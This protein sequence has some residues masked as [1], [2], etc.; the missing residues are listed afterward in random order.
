MLSARGVAVIAALVL[1]AGCDGSSPSP[2]PTTTI[3]AAKPIP[4]AGDCMAKE[5][6]D[7]DD[8]APDLNSRVD[9]TKPH[10][11]EVTAVLDVPERF[12]TGTTPQ[13]IMAQR[14]TL[15]TVSNESKANKKF[16]DYA[17]KRCR[18]AGVA[19]A[20]LSGLKLRGTSAV[21]ANVYAAVV[22]VNE[23]LNLLDAGNWAK[24]NTKFLCTIRYSKHQTVLPD[25][26]E[27]PEP[28]AIRSP[29]KNPVM[30]SFLAKDFPLHHRQCLA[31]GAGRTGTPRSC[32]KPH[33]GEM[34][35]SFDA[36]PVFGTK[37]VQSIGLDLP[38][39]AE[40]RKLNEPCIDALPSFLGVDYDKDLTA[41]TKIGSQG[42]VAQG[43][44]YPTYCIVVAR[45]PKLDLPA[46]S[47]IGNAKNV[48]LVPAGQ[49]QV[50]WLD[51]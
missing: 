5:V 26:E 34:L 32:E 23:W 37:F 11:Y 39:K 41:V 1:L 17:W 40:A 6:P 13:E 50:A 35:F 42:W 21:D 14:K 48:D 2:K 7:L 29:S 36:R 19:A 51:R 47:L 18:A 30:A 8:F 38:S 25:R 33:Q 44:Y 27:P 20:R 22:D 15:A 24:G 28:E 10:V 4:E 49:S 31:I 16:D 43:A 46:G 3:P 12:L 9:C 45:N